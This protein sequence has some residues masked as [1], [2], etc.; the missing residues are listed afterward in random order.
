[1]GALHRSWRNTPQIAS[2]GV[3]A[4]AID[5]AARESYLH[6]EFIPLAEHSRRTTSADAQSLPIE[7]R[8]P[9]KTGIAPVPIPRAAPA[10]V[11]PSCWADQAHRDSSPAQ[12]SSQPLDKMRHFRHRL[13]S[14]EAAK[15]PTRGP[16][17]LVPD[18]PN[19]PIAHSTKFDTFD[20]VLL[21]LRHPH[22]PNR[23]AP[24]TKKRRSEP[25]S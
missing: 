22:G 21:P 10:A 6:R 16:K 2:I 23:P 1:M 14:A 15:N 11:L 12:S 7:P 5:E 25:N 19:R 18:S 8:N 9:Y 17:I 4:E 13:P 24:H 3:V 20:T